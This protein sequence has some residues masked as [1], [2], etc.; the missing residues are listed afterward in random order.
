LAVLALGGILQAE[1]AFVPEIREV[2]TRP[3]PT[4]PPMLPTVGAVDS[5]FVLG[6]FGKF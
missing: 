1:L 4:P 3:L 5:G 2:R 6:V